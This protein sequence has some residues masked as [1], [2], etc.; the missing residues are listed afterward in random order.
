MIE[1]NQIEIHYR[2]CNI[3]KV[4]EY[5]V[6]CRER[7][8]EPCTANGW[9]YWIWYRLGESLMTNL[10]KNEK[11]VFRLLSFSNSWDENSKL[12]KG[13]KNSNSGHRIIPAILSHFKKVKNRKSPLSN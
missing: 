8:G 12:I 5:S 9:I 3:D 7:N 10:R 1:G 13:Y 6:V 4:H 2:Y 11:Q